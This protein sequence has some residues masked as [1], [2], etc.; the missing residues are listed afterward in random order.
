MRGKQNMPEQI[1]YIA[2]FLASLKGIHLKEVA[3]QTTSNALMLF[4]I[5]N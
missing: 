5:T 3:T 1:R 4:G 2:Q